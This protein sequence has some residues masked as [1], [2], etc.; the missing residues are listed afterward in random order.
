M[1]FNLEFS[2]EQCSELLSKMGYKTDMVY[3]YFYKDVDPYGKEQ[4]LDSLA[5][6]VYYRGDKP[7]ELCVER[8]MIENCRK[9]L[10]HNVFQKVF[11]NWLF[12]IMLKHSPFCDYRD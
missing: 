4:E 12:N 8:P 3:L 11:N 5:C 10:F 7:K 2:D 1:T 9:Y 6:K